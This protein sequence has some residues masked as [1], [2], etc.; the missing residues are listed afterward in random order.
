MKFELDSRISYSEPLSITGRKWKDKQ[1]S[2]LPPPP[3]LKKSSL[4]YLGNDLRGILLKDLAVDGKICLNRTSFMNLEHEG[5]KVDL[6]AW[7]WHIE[8]DD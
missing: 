1:I 8:S 5:N 3:D 6:I 4:D 7:K 2:H